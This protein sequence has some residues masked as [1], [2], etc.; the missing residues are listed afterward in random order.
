MNAIIFEWRKYKYILEV[1]TDYTVR[2][3]ARLSARSCKR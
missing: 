2:V 3:C 1:S